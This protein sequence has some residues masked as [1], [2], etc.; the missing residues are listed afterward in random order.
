MY[1]IIESFL[2]SIIDLKWAS[3]TGKL[4]VFGGI[5]INCEG[6]MTD[7]F[8]PLKFLVISKN[9]GRVDLTEE[10]F[11]FKAYKVKLP[12]PKKEQ[13]KKNNI[14]NSIKFSSGQKSTEDS[15]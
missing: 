9:D 3:E 6:L 1:G 12:A 4:S 8:L 5:T 11:G 13:N 7:M 2:Q 15:G 10:C 14:D